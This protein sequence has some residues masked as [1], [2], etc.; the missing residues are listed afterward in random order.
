[1]QYFYEINDN[2]ESTAQQNSLGVSMT[3]RID[4]TVSRVFNLADN[5]KRSAY[6][7]LLPQVQPR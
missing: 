1:M 2:S 3:Y 6:R 7:Y 5:W 4:S